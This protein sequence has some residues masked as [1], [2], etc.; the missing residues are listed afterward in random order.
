M[1]GRMRVFDQRKVWPVPI[2]AAI[3][4]AGAAVADQTPRPVADVRGG[5]AYFAPYDHTAADRA[6]KAFDDTHRQCSLWS[7]WH[8]L[9]SRTGP[10]GATYCRTDPTYPVKPSAPFCADTQ[11]IPVQQSRPNEFSPE[12][13]SYFRFSRI[14]EYKDFINNNTD[15]KSAVLTKYRVWQT[16]RPFNGSRF[17]QIFD[18]ECEVWW[19]P[20]P[21]LGPSECSFT[22]SSGAKS[23]STTR[24]RSLI[25][26]ASRPS[27]LKWRAD[28]GC[29][30]KPSGGGVDDRI[31]ETAE[32]DHEISIA[33][34]GKSSRGFP[35]Y[36]SACPGN[37]EP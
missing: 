12:Q 2:A 17:Q 10:R 4:L 15:P 16:R 30:R 21:T 20:D 13:K 32:D 29:S 22:P 36:A 23:C 31:S 1:S 34:N 6:L 27:C 14:A 8:K 33:Q 28:S 37:S 3:V 35:V 11:D 26:N 24:I 25:Y 19:F 5:P 9:C 18:P 7:D